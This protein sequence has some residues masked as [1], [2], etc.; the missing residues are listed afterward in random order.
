M[1]LLGKAGGPGFLPV[2]FKSRLLPAPWTALRWGRDLR[3]THQ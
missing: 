2:Q 3:V 1:A